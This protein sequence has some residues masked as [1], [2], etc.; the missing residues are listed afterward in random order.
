[1]KTNGI[2]IFKII[3]A[4]QM[5]AGLALTGAPVFSVP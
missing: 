5:L 2:K 3:L 4:A 1:M